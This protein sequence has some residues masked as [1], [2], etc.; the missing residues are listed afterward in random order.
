MIMYNK[1][2]IAFFSLC[3]FVLFGNA[4]FANEKKDPN[5]IFILTDDLGYGDVS[6]LNANGKIPT[7]N[8]DRIAQSGVT[9]T[10]AHSSSAVC[11]PTRYGILTGRYNWRSTLKQGVLGG[12]SKALIPPGRKTM[13]AMLK[14]RGYQTAC[15]GK[16]HLGWDW[17]NIGK[18]EDSIDFSKQISNGPTTLGFDYFYGFSG[19][20]DM[21]PYVYVE[22]DRPTSLP[23]RTTE[24]N[25]KPVG[26][27]G[28]DGSYWR[29][30]PTGSDFSHEDCLSNLTQ[31]AV[32]YIKENAKSVK[33]FFLYFPMPAPHTPILP[34]KE[35]RGKSGLN[36]YA[37]YVLM[38]DFEVGE[39]LK[40]IDQ[41]GEKDNTLVVFASDNGCSPWADFISLK[42]KGH[43]PSFIFRGN[44]ADLF[45]GGHR[46][47]CLIQWPAKIKS[48]HIVS[49]TVCLNDFMATFANIAGYQFA[50]NEAEDSYNLLPAI[51]NPGY[52][53]IIREA[54]VHHSIN[55]SFT[56]RKGDWKLLLA[57]GSGGWSSPKPGKEEEGL[58]SVQLYN[59]KSDPAE[60]DN[61]QTKYP[62]V[63]RELTALLKKYVEDGRSTPGNKQNNDG[64]YPWKQI[65]FLEIKD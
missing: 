42:A 49:Q 47:P 8:I 56:I 59:L 24:G 41:S 20:L 15:M 39:I 29:K 53:K 38:V 6:F 62:E 52:R 19:S 44:K 58:P 27:P 57:A 54:T 16:W 61:L 31:R 48:P 7:P 18:G 10:D 14:S 40:S 35:F 60:K 45:D 33:P 50:D 26:S 21:P 43:N 37:D 51:L 32:K 65:R 11:S 55:G 30:G 36:S 46:I 1:T 9:F 12:Y 25:N 4:T 23:V 34:S 13:A 22:N 63:V 17:N 3:G 5:I 64:E 28:S 2:Q